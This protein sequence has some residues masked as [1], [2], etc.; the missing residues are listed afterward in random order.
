MV[1]TMTNPS[2]RLALLAALILLAGSATAQ[3]PG[4]VVLK[5]TVP[6]NTPPEAELAIGAAFNA[7]NPA[8]GRYG[9]TRTA[10]G[11]WL[12]E[13][14]KFEA[15]KVLQ[16]KV[17]RGTWASV[18]VAAD[19]SPIDNRRYVV[20]PGDQVVEIT[21]AGW[22][23]QTEAP[24]V[25]STAIGTIIEETVELPTFSGP[26][27][28][29]IY[30]PPDYDE[31]D[32]RYPVIYMTDGRNLFDVAVGATNEWGMDEL[33]E[34]LA[35]EESPLTSIVVGIDHAGDDRSAEYSP[36]PNRWR[37]LGRT[38]GEGQ[39]WA[40]WLVG[41]LKP[42]IDARYRTLPGREHTTLMGSSMGGLISCYTA[43]RHQAVISKA[44]CY[45][46]AFL[47][48]LVGEDWLNF[49][50]ET[51]R[52]APMRIHMDMGDAELD[53]FGEAILDEMAEVEATMRA[54]G[55]GEDELRYQVIEQG[56]HTESDWRARTEDI[57][58]WLNRVD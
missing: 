20:Q 13:L 40:D 45:S 36:W 7:W 47:K 9:L 43:V 18:E 54:S 6:Q 41:T 28:L 16:F 39:A 30:L 14:P 27:R 3:E 32:R 42:S 35:K 55:F 15:G 4:Q 5:I 23:D 48:R 2:R 34:R 31:G 49:I 10:N 56:V 8:R 57:L 25:A 37:L 22:E 53:L 17:T 50:R 38:P 46:P 21:V 51:G 1:R 52:D 24:P 11:V 33:M 19:G 29:W 26:R 44:G 58:R 12:G